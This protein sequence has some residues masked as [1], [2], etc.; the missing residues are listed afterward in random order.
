MRLMFEHNRFRGYLL[1]AVV[2][3]L[4]YLSLRYT[5]TTTPRMRVE[6]HSFL[7]IRIGAI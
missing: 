7:W 3:S 1:E 6:R 4:G 2:E 5:P